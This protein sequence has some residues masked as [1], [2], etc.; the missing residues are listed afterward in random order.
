[1]S[2]LKGTPL[3]ILAMNLSMAGF[4]VNDALA[5]AASASIPLGQLMFT[6]GLMAS[7]LILVVCWATGALK[8]L[9]ALRHPALV[10][11]VIGE[12]GA[13]LCYLTA[14]VHIPLSNVTAIFMASP[15][16]VTAAAAVFLAEPVGW[17][18]WTA[19]LV[20]FAGVL[21]I[22]R[23]GLEGFNGYGLLVLL[24]VAFVALRDLATRQMPKEVPTF[25]ATALTAVVITVTGVVMMPIESLFSNF[26]TWQP[27]QTKTLL[28]LG[29]G[30]CFLLVGYVFVIV[31]MRNGDMSAVAPFRYTSLVFALLID[32]FVFGVVLD[33][34]TLVGAAVIVASGLYTLWRERVRARTA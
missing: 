22:V 30:A 13:T 14:L 20:G 16:A 28:Q 12:L 26:D 23:P 5:K 33:T 6:R 21:V 7:A 25:L 4:V 8:A 2:A 10:W 3:G 1:M 18:R 32:V 15:L 24:A 27:L 31:A 17:R 11:R 29:F 9:G 19:I 34:P